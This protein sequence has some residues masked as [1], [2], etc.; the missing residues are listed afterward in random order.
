MTAPH[1]LVH[2]RAATISSRAILTLA[3]ISS[4]IVV[5]APGCRL[6]A[7]SGDGREIAF[8]SIPFGQPHCQR[9]CL[10]PLPHLGPPPGQS[11][12]PFVVHFLNMNRIM[13]SLLF[14]F[15]R[16]I[17]PL[18]GGSSRV[19]RRRRR[20][21]PPFISSLDQPHLLRDL[22]VFS[23]SPQTV[24]SWPRMEALLRLRR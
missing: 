17:S 3:K 12:F 13:P 7:S 24:A 20:S 8:D 2:F 15:C 5:L 11:T 16:H 9:C 14:V 4:S 21:S 18:Q 22:V 1:P 19:N 23:L 10:S 6:T